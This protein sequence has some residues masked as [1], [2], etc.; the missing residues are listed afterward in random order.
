MKI[1]KKRWLFPILLAIPIGLFVL[2]QLN[3][4]DFSIDTQFFV[5]N[6]DFILKKDASSMLICR[7][8][9]YTDELKE[10]LKNP[11]QPF[12]QKE[13]WV[14]EKGHLSLLT[15]RV[16]GKKYIIKRYNPNLTH[17][18]LQ[19]I[20]HSSSQAVRAFYYSYQFD[21]MEIKSAK[22]IA[23][24]EKKW[25]FFRGTCYQIVEYIHGMKGPH[26]FD[27]QRIPDIDYEKSIKKT[28]ALAQKLEHYNLIHGKLNLDS[29][30]Y[31]HET[32]YLIDLDHVHHYRSKNLF[33][34]R[35]RKARDLD[36]LFEDFDSRLRDEERQYFETCYHAQITDHK[37]NA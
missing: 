8:E 4:D 33:F 21:K 24:I 14:K 34:R 27:D 10:L 15:W 5:N 37:S 18:L 23:V 22:S 28:L 16:N 31:V 6:P 29:F 1:Y 7:S 26:F 36:A 2:K 9:Y 13:Q 19:L 32:P 11:E 30:F 17:W 20:P 25:G 35:K 3:P 12:K